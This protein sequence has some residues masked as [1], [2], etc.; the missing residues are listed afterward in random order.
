[1]IA[2]ELTKIGRSVLRRRVTLGPVPSFLAE[3]AERD[4][5]HIKLQIL[6]V[7]VHSFLSQVQSFSFSLKKMI[8][9]AKLSAESKAFVAFRS[10]QLQSA[11]AEEMC[12][13][14]PCCRQTIFSV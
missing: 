14:S 13:G 3:L 5:D 6:E 8:S 1:M 4:C 10:T 11:G 9:G 2:H 7:I 12:G